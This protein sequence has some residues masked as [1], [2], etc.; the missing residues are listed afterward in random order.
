MRITIS[1]LRRIIK[2]EVKR[3]INENETPTHRIVTYS[4]YGS[5]KDYPYFDEESAMTAYNAAVDAGKD[6]ELTTFDGSQ[7]WVPTMGQFRPNLN[8]RVR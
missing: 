1:D 6:V 8:P 7:R 5:E 2:E 4:K 3:A